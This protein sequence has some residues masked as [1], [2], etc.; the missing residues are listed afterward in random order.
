MTGLQKTGFVYLSVST[1]VSTILTILYRTSAEKPPFFIQFPILQYVLLIGS[2]FA[3]IAFCYF[4]HKRN[5]DKLSPGQAYKAY[6]GEKYPELAKKLYPLGLMSYNAHFIGFMKDRDDEAED[7]ILKN[8]KAY[9][10]TNILLMVWG[11][12]ITLIFSCIN[13]L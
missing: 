10:K 3:Y 4:R 6:I 7:E 12:M 9:H 2:V 11:F 13:S 1:L 8:M 5:P